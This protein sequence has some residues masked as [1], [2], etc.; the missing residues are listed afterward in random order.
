MNDIK[1]KSGHNEEISTDFDICAFV[2]CLFIITK[3]II[4]I[5]Y[6]DYYNCP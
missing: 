3:N 4:R 6:D 2:T 5:D 1:E